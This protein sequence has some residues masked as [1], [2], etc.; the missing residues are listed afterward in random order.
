MASSSFCKCSR[1]T[2]HFCRRSEPGGAGMARQTGLTGWLAA[3]VLRT[4][5]PRPQAGPHPGA[6]RPVGTRPPAAR[7]AGA[8][9]APP[10]VA[11]WRSPGARGSERAEKTWRRGV[12]RPWPLKTRREQV[13][14]SQQTAQLSD[15][16]GSRLKQVACGV[17]TCIGRQ[18]L[19][20]IWPQWS[21]AG[22][23][24]CPRGTHGHPGS[25]HEA[26]KKAWPSSWLVAS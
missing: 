16:H 20:A 7:A 21:C 23:R 18:P 5:A 4:G 10:A 2:G 19:S 24:E 8:S 3:A 15:R 14:R 11:G 17:E 1:V 6:P 12:Q 25:R 9:S 26:E 13:G 22:Q